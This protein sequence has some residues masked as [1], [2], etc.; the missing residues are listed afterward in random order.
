[1]IKTLLSIYKRPYVVLALVIILQL[2]VLV[3]YMNIRTVLHCDE[4]WSYGLANSYNQ[5]FL[6]SGENWSNQSNSFFNNWS[7]GKTYFDYITVQPKER[8]A[9]DRVYKNQVEYVHPPP[10]SLFYITL[11]LFGFSE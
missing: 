2:C 8:F 3:Y 1:M 4:V 11:G 5:A 10:S 6:C 9:F 7:E